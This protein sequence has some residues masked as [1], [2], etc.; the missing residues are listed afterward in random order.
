MGILTKSKNTAAAQAL[1]EA[2]D[3]LAVEAIDRTGLIVTSEG[4]LVRMLAVTP[5]N[6]LIL[7]A[8]ERAQ[9]AAAFCHLV[10]RL[11][12]EQ[13]LQFYVQARPV[14]LP[15]ILADCRREVQAWAGEPPSPNHGARDPLALSRWRM[16]SAME[17]SLRQH[18]DDQAAMHVQ[19]YVVVPYVPSQQAARAVL[20]QFKPGRRLPTSAL[21]RSITDHRRAVRESLAHTDSIRAELDALNLP[22]RLLNGEEAV[23]LLWSR[24]NPT[25]SDRG[26]RP[27]PSG[28]EIVGELDTA[29]DADEARSAALKLRGIVAR[30]PLDFKDS[31][32]HA[33]IHTDVEQTI[34][35]ANTA[36]ATHMGWLMAAMMTRQPYSLSVYVHALDRARERTRLKRGYRRTFAINRGAESRGR[37]PDFDRYAKEHEQQRLLAEM[38]GT[39]RA[40]LFEVSIYQSI[41]SRGP[42]PDVASLHEAVDYCAEQIESSSD[43]K[44]NRGKWQQQDLW[45]SSLPLG[46]DIAKRTR[47][48]ATRNVGDHIPLV[49][50][51]CGSPSGVPFAFSDPGREL[52]HW[53]PWDR[54]HSNGMMIVTGQSGSGKTNTLNM[55]LSRSIGMGA[56]AFVLD[57]A[58]HFSVLVDLVDGARQVALG[59]EDAAWA[60]N[61]WD[62]ADPTNVSL[63]KIAFLVSL[64][65]VM[66]GEEGMSTLERAQLGAAIRAVYGKCAAGVQDGA[67]RESML[68]DELLARCAAE[69]A[70]GDHSLS[71]LLRNVAERLG[72]FCG[73]GAYAYLLDRET[74]VPADSSLVVFDTR[75]VPEVVLRPVMF[76][77][78]EFVT[79]TVERH[80]DGMSDVSARP[81][82][83]IM[84]G[85]SIVVIDEGWHM[86]GRK[87]TGEYAN[88]LARRSRHLG[89]ALIVA[90]QQLSDFNTE[91]GVALLRNATQLLFLA[92]NPDE[93]AWAKE[94]LRLSY[95]VAAVITRLKT[96]KGS[97]AQAFWINGT[98]GSGQVAIRLGNVEQWAFTSDPVRDAPT[99]TQAIAH[100]G[101]VWAAIHHLAKHGPP[102]QRGELNAPA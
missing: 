62:V 53:N 83:P 79:R 69:R 57:R 14:N 91:H 56:R 19:A 4:A 30:S 49:G 66:M 47:K 3:L 87:E 2:G 61:P 37:V 13:S 102:G 70:E 95:Q 46:R 93:V 90:S 29:S 65:G 39:D 11:R 101:N 38:A 89:C 55:L 36:E 8:Q 42:Q 7:S 86:V 60:I 63:E 100:H 45:L 78:L 51:S 22:V 96:V 77:T 12:P 20:E 15:E 64:H 18:A 52:Q 54:S 23:A 71:T 25:Q 82:A 26:R 6:P 81:D 92:Q 5:P 48:Y 74:N 9:T 73:D 21:E 85:K 27:T 67:P 44:V 76:A 88:D 75:R 58:G 40:N 94:V 24:F 33:V 68:R 72:E 32:D 80:R 17:E 35:A 16:Y 59:A 34:Y 99:R 1:P 97:H 41:R 43:C 10:C 31:A 50:T 84:A 28:T 98:R